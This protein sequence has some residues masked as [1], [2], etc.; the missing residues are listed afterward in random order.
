MKLLIV[1][2]DKFLANAYELKFTQLGYEVKI[3]TNG[4]EA[5]KILNDFKPGVILT[6]ILM[7]EYNGIK[8]LN[9]L[10]DH[11]ELKTVPVV[12]ASQLSGKKDI[13]KCMDLGVKE[14]IIKSDMTI[15]DLEQKIRKY[16]N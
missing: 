8:L 7:P 9:Y 6:D 4:D 11:P 16:F 13:D 12:V 1:E 2:D 3:A 5:V 14:Y 10:K 15:E